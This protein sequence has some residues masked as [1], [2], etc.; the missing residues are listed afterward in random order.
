MIFYEEEAKFLISSISAGSISQH[1]RRSYN[2]SANTGHVTNGTPAMIASSTEFHPQCVMN[3][4][5]AE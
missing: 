1:L 2:C 3:P 4:P 5:I